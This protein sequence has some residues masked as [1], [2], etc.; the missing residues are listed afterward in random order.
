MNRREEIE[1]FDVWITNAHA[2]GLPRLLFVGD[3]IPGS[4]YPT[5]EA[6]LRGNF[7]CARL[8]TSKSVCD[9]SFRR[10]LDFVLAEYRFA[11]MTARVR[12]R[13]QLA[14]AAARA[15]I[16]YR[17]AGALP[18][19]GRWSV[20]RLWEG[21]TPLNCIVAAEKKADC[22]QVDQQTSNACGRDIRETGDRGKR[23]LT[24]VVHRR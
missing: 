5:V 16:P 17:F 6:E 8:A 12:Q 24:P 20:S 2:E 11:A 23:E 19:R 18:D 10:D 3:S 15:G 22:R 1:W 13:N 21:R 7:H 14:R 4:Y 9:A